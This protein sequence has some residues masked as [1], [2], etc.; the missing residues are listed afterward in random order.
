M[1]MQFLNTK[2]RL[3]VEIPDDQVTKR[4]VLSQT[5]RGNQRKTYMFQAA[6]PEDGT[7]MSKFTSAAGFSSIPGEVVEVVKP[8]KEAAAS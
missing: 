8:P 3:Q 1:F 5:T 6:D 4:L 7:V 2:R